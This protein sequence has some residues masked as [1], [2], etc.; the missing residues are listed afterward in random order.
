[1]PHLIPNRSGIFLRLSIDNQMMMAWLVLF[2][3]TNIQ[4]PKSIGCRQSK[5]K[6]LKIHGLHPACCAHPASKQIL[7]MHQHFCLFTT[8]LEVCCLNFI[9]PQR[10]NDSASLQ[11]LTA[12]SSDLSH[13]PT[14]P[15]L[16]VFGVLCGLQTPCSSRRK[17]G[18]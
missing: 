3:Y 1:M 16:V 7:E 10:N 2:E 18:L 9:K 12:C 8:L 13:L 11:T 17:D 15:W 5:S 14:I 6:S 4:K